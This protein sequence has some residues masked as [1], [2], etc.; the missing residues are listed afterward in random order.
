M[1]VIIGGNGGGREAVTDSPHLEWRSLFLGKMALQAA[2]NSVRLL[3]S[4]RVGENNTS[5]AEKQKQK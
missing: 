1:S 3:S 4:E 5:E 2:V